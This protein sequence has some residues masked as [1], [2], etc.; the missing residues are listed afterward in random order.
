ME[1]PHFCS[2]IQEINSIFYFILVILSFF[3]IPEVPVAQGVPPPRRVK[4]P[5]KSVCYDVFSLSRATARGSLAIPRSLQWRGCACL[6]RMR[7]A[8]RC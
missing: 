2:G 6:E 5:K 7:R 1:R 3:C 4:N 8:S